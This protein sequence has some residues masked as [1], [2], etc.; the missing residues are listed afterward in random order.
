MAPEF[1]AEGNCATAHNPRTGE[2]FEMPAVGVYQ[3]HDR[4][5]IDAACSISIL[6][7]RGASWNAL[8]A[9]ATNK[10][11]RFTRNSTSQSIRAGAFMS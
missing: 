1:F 5:A 8:R 11:S 10:A 4:R 3:M 6:T 9:S 7:R 2:R